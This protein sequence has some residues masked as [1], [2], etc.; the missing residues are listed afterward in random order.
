MIEKAGCNYPA[1][2]YA[3]PAEVID[4]VTGIASLISFVASL[5]A[6]WCHSLVQQNTGHR[7]PLC[8]ALLGYAF[9]GKPEGRST[10]NGLIAFKD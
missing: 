9:G 5:P 3:A 7:C 2:L 8:A 4:C 1:F 10:A 6:G